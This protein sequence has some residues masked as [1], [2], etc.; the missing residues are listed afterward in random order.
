M[1]VHGPCAGMAACL[2]GTGKLPA[3]FSPQSQM[4]SS[5]PVHGHRA[6]PCIGYPYGSDAELPAGS[7]EEEED[8]RR[9]VGEAEEEGG[10]G[11]QGQ[12]GEGKG[13]EAGRKGRGKGVRG[14]G[15][16]KGKGGEGEGAQGT[17]GQGEGA[18]G[19]GVFVPD[20]LSPISYWSVS[21]MC[22]GHGPSPV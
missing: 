17:G 21:T 2:H 22:S 16:G 15:E 19:I 1:H 11:G 13:G 18:V 3:D 5:R 12:G 6:K 4:L 14:R 20:G 10:G 9:R 7:W 8:T